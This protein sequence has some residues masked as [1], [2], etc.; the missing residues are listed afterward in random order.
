MFHK[1]NLRI[2]ISDDCLQI[3]E[4]ML[5][6]HPTYYNNKSDVIRAGIFALKRWRVHKDGTNESDGIRQYK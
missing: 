1:N 5:R 6:D 3:I 2:R 4:E